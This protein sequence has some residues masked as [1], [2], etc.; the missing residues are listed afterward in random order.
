M[1]EQAWRSRIVQ[2]FFLLAAVASSCAAPEGPR[3]PGLPDPE[4]PGP[5]TSSGLAGGGAGGDGGM[6]GATGDGGTGGAGGTGGTA[7]TGGA[8]GTGG[9]LVCDPGEVMCGGAC[10][11]TQ[12]DPMNCGVCGHVC[13]GSVCQ[14]SRCLLSMAS[15]ASIAVDDTYVYWT[16]SAP[17]GVYRIP[18]L[19]GG[20]VQLT[21]TGV[22]HPR[23]IRVDATNVYWVNDAVDG[24]VMKMPKAGGSPVKILDGIEY[25]HG[26]AIDA[27][28]AYVATRIP[29]DNDS[30]QGDVWQVSLEGDNLLLLAE[31]QAFPSGIAVDGLYV[32]WAS[33]FKEAVMK[34]PIGGGPIVVAASAQ[35][36]LLRI[37]IDASNLYWTTQKS[38]VKMSLDSGEI[39]TLAD[40]WWVLTNTVATNGAYVYYLTSTELKKV[41]VVGGAATVM[42]NS[43]G[44]TGYIAVDA[45]FIYLV[46][47]GLWRIAK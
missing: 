17:L 15:C 11:N 1:I 3:H 23:G 12:D 34:T 40:E 26:L 35:S 22:D 2:G 24:S 19:G 45:Q 6:G 27:T 44:I 16:S 7:G 31:G 4:G 32:Y 14:A 18:R 28:N 10:V 47:G 38:V 42:T 8:G 39:T 46:E 37:T 5:T 9:S 29:S 21:D 20:G 41:P 13:E 43:N 36:N 30:K 33:A 25:P